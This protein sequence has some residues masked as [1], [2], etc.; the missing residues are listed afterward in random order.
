ME[1][2]R[3]VPAVT[4]AIGPEGD[5]APE[6]IRLAER[7]GSVRIGLGPLVLRVETAAIAAVSTILLGTGDRGVTSE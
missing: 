2:L 3:T 7:N 6:E 4:L 1:R 5:W